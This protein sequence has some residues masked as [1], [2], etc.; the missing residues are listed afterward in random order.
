MLYRPN[1]H[2]GDTAA[3]AVEDDE[4]RPSER[5][6]DERAVRHN[7]RRTRS[8]S[9]SEPKPNCELSHF[10]VMPF[11]V[12]GKDIWVTISKAEAKKIGND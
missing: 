10:E 4:R 12:L 8:R 2:H 6:R 1:L 7:S 5:W 3:A 9:K 11:V